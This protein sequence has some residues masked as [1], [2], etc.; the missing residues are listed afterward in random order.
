MLVAG[1]LGLAVP[2]RSAAGLQAPGGK[3]WSFVVLGHLRGD[4]YGP[5]PKLAELL[6]EVREL[7]PRFVVLTGD[8][9][10]GDVHSNPADTT[11]LIAE[12]T[13]LDS[14]LATLGVPVYRVPGN[15]DISDR[16]SR[17]VYLRR[18]GPLPQAVDRD[19]IRLLLL[20]S[21]WIPT[22]QDTLKNPYVRGRDLDSTQLA[23][24][25]QEL[26]RPG[27]GPTFVFVHHLLWWERETGPWWREVHPLLAQAGVPLV[28]SGD[29]G[30]LK[31]STTTRDGVRYVQSSIE[32][33]VSMAIQRGMIT[34]RI[35]SSQFDNYLEVVVAGAAAEVK[36][37]TV[38]EFSSGQFT[39]ERYRVVNTPLP[40]KPVPVWRR[41][42]ELIGSP[43]RLLALG[44]GAGIL[45]AAGW[46]A[47][48]RRFRREVV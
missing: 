41:I 44:V 30:P 39:L 43:R 46:W 6:A 18:Y 26:A 42:W 47:G 29:Y 12:W 33:S 15:H 21:T 22:D 17:D 40:P 38:A 7:R 11:K 27:A 31:F 8:M 24:L 5:N 16:P 1:A 34:S 14:A 45:F 35:L 13:Y 10:W 25:R 37:H 9:I 23:W 48:R 32:D 36:V 4:Q 20:T 2:S 19:G 28:F 3:P